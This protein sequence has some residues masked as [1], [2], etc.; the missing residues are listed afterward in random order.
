M[1]IWVSSPY[2]LAHSQPSLKLTS[3][4]KGLDLCYTN[5]AIP[6]AV[7]VQ[8]LS[9]SG[10]V[11]K[12]MLIL[13]TKFPIMESPTFFYALWTSFLTR[14]LLHLIPV[15]YSPFVSC[16]FLSYYSSF[17]PFFA[18]YHL[19]LLA[20]QTPNRS[21]MDPMACSFVLLLPDVHLY[22]M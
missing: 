11:G 3:W 19:S 7:R 20:Y 2:L 13:I 10:L 17:L 8:L 6:K 16:C 9:K 21:T 18:V 14:Y 12:L 22:V 15:V 5:S 1:S 4:S